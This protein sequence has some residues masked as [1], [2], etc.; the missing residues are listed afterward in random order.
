MGEDLALEALLDASTLPANTNAGDP[1][2]KKRNPIDS[3]IGA[4]R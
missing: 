1:E 4:G 2:M 3:G